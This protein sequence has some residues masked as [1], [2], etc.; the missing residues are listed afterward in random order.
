MNHSFNFVFKFKIIFALIV[1]IVSSGDGME[2]CPWW[3]ETLLKSRIGIA[4]QWAIGIARNLGDL[5][6]TFAVTINN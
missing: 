1:E 6:S 3:A 2:K 4:A 5:G